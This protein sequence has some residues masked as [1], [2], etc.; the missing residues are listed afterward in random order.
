MQSLVN[1]AVQDMLPVKPPSLSRNA[2]YCRAYRQR[3]KNVLNAKKRAFYHS[4]K[5]IAYRQSERYKQLKAAQNARH[6]VKR[7]AVAK[8]VKAMYDQ[9]KTS[10]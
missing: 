9:L 8:V 3:N 10:L 5:G 1:E 6:R 2:E 4:E 7:Q